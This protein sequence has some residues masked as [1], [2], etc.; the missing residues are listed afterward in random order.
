[1]KDKVA[2]NDHG[3]EV[4]R[5]KKTYYSNLK[6]FLGSVENQLRLM[7]VVI[8]QNFVSWIWM[9]IYIYPDLQLQSLDRGC[10]AGGDVQH[11]EWLY[12]GTDN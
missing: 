9:S 6:Y 8:V 1:M 7:K 4:C 10:D 2:K 5:K 12:V 3:L 11:S